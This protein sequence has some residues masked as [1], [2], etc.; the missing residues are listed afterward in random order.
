M[1]ITANMAQFR[2]SGKGVR[3]VLIAL[4][5]VLAA[6]CGGDEPTGP[7]PAPAPP[8]IRIQNNSAVTLIGVFYKSCS[9]TEY[10]DD[11]LSGSIAPGGTQTFTEGVTAGCWDVAVTGDGETFGFVTGVTVSGETTV[12]FVNAG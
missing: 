5:L 1:T 8:A 6:G 10:S 3:G 4:A 7:G 2:R 12:T 11:R 9:A